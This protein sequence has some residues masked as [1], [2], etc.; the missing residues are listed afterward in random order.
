[1]KRFRGLLVFVLLIASVFFANSINVLAETNTKYLKVNN[2]TLEF[3]EIIYVDGTN[4]DD[5]NG[6]GSKDKPFKNVV[7]GFDY[8]NANCREGGAIVINDGTL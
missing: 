5:T 4:G 8:L 7:K 6:D 3:K 1:M 2:T